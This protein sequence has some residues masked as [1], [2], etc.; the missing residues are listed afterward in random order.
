MSAAVK[1]ILIIKPSALGDIV[2]A[3]PVLNGLRDSFPDTKIDWFVR[4]EFVPL[5]DNH[6][7]IDDLVIFDRK[8]MGQW[9]KNR[10]AMGKFRELLK[11]LNSPNYDIVFDFQ[12]LLRTGFFAK[13][14]GSKKRVGMTIAREMSPLFYNYKVEP[15][16]ESAHVLD[17][18]FKMIEAVGAKRPE[19]IEYG[20]KLDDD[21]VEYVDKLLSESGVGKFAVLVSSSAQEY[22]C[23]G[24]EKFARLGEMMSEKFGLQ[25]VTVGTENEKSLTG[26]IAELSAVKVDDLAGKTNIKQ[27]M[28][29]L[30]KA[31]IIVSNDTGPGYIGA[32]LG[33]ASVFIYGPTNPGRVAPYGKYDVAA[34]VNAY[35]RGRTVESE[36]DEHKIERVTVEMVFEKVCKQLEKG[37]N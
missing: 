5:I 14:S 3:L 7:W 21:A 20:L 8:Q 31:D 6:P 27:L 2:H 26:K 4:K 13:A 30:A 10:Q 15:P 34:A 17:Y 33:R 1:K 28:A 19:R 16:Q 9:W 29:V 35:D 32:A 18:Y 24:V 37:S 25:I 22:K 12:G 23:W 11:K 36:K